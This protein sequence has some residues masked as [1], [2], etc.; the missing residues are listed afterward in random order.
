MNTKIARIDV[1]GQYQM[2]VERKDRFTRPEY[3]HLWHENCYSVVSNYLQ[4][5]EVLV[6]FRAVAVKLHEQSGNRPHLRHV[7]ENP[8]LEMFKTRSRCVSRYLMA[9]FKKKNGFHW[10]QTFDRSYVLF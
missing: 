9:L 10:H 5:E 7:H 1:E 8:S 3:N 6:L 2:Y 4:R